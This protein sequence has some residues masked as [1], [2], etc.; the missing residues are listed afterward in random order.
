M[1][2]TWGGLALAQNKTPWLHLEVQEKKNDPGLVKVNLPLSMVDSAL[3][4]VKDEKFKGGRLKLDTK[5]IRVAD[6]KQLWDELKKA[7]DAEF[8]SVEKKNETVH[9][10]RQGDLLLVNIAESGK[11]KTKVDLKIP[12]AVVEALLQGPGD[13][14]N[15]K[16]ALDAMRDRNVGEVLTVNDD[17]SH[18]R[19]WID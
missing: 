2:C 8:V 10:S 15:I 14:L 12:V 17:H 9:V 7:G 18:V 3:N 11:K 4:I 13:E 19:L 6:L 5:D 16:A 1:L